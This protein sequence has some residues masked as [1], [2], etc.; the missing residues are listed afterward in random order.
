MSFPSQANAPVPRKS[1]RFLERGLKLGSTFVV[2][3]GMILFVSQ[4]WVQ[5]KMG[6][7]YF[8]KVTSNF[9]YSL[10]E[11]A[12]IR[13]VMEWT[14]VDPTNLRMNT[15]EELVRYKLQML[16]KSLNNYFESLLLETDKLVSTAS[17]SS[18][19]I[20]RSVPTAE[21]RST[22]R[23]SFKQYLSDNSDVVEVSLFDAKGNRLSSVKYK[24]LQDYALAPEVLKYFSN[25]DNLVVKG[26]NSKD[27]VIVSSVRNKN[28][29]IGFV[30]QTVSSYFFTKILDFLNINQNLFYIRGPGDTTLVDNQEVYSYLN[31]GKKFSYSYLFYE[32][33]T[34]PTETSLDVNIDKVDY[35]VGMVLPKNNLLGHFMGLVIL[36]I[37]LQIASVAVGILFRSVQG[38]LFSGQVGDELANLSHVNLQEELSQSNEYPALIEIVPHEV[39]AI[40]NVNQWNVSKDNILEGLDRSDFEKSM[41]EVLKRRDFRL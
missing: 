20:A 29:L 19:L 32:R 35:S 10:T 4:P 1:R 38:M 30:C 28:V 26:P 24:G 15:R 3:L 39:A 23:R 31:D 40:P 34:K 5:E 16:S 8:W 7:S 14:V 13:K 21:K 33:L 2:L 27:L 9:I 11:S 18:M 6:G 22:V 36:L 17:I 37:M 12:P 41:S 25:C